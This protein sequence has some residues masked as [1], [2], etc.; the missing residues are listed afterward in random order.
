MNERKYKEG[1]RPTAW[2]M[3]WTYSGERRKKMTRE[4]KRR[5]IISLTFYSMG[6]SFIGESRKL[7]SRKPAATA[8]DKAGARQYLGPLREWGAAASDRGYS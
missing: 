5:K 1:Y 4:R 2:R 7:M 3:Q 6:D 8:Q